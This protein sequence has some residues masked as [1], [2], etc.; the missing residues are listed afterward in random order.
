M[1][2]EPADAYKDYVYIHNSTDA[3]VY[4]NWTTKDD[5]EHPAEYWDYYALTFVG[6]NYVYEALE[7]KLTFR[8]FAILD[9]G[10]GGE[11]VEYGNNIFTVNMYEIADN[12]YQNQKI[13]TKEGHEFLYDNILNVVTIKNN[14]LGICQ[15]ML[16]ALN[17]TSASD[18]NY[19]LANG[20]YKD[21]LNYVYCQKG[22]TYHS[23]SGSSGH[24]AFEP[25][26]IDASKLLTNLNAASGTAYSTVFD[27]IYSETG[28]YGYN[29]FYKKVPY[30][31]DN[32]IY[33]DYIKK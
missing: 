30:A 23:E 33:K 31:W 19:A 29:G 14:R 8:A 9:D 25:I 18:E 3:G 20:T 27:W 28:K 24:G 13:S 5:D 22:Y 32:G 7:E 2:L 17:V 12:L 15:S 1:V 21:M 11:I 10:N 16:K 6:K 26:N 4:K